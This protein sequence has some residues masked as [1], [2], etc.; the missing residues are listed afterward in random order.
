[1]ILVGE[2][3]KKGKEK[4]SNFYWNRISK[5]TYFTSDDYYSVFVYSN[6]SP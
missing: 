5:Q 4:K 2:K 1:M 3:K 6:R